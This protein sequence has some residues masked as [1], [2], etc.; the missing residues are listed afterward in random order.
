MKI[1]I[2]H[3]APIQTNCTVGNIFAQAR[4]LKSTYFKA[5][6]VLEQYWQVTLMDSS[7]RI[8]QE[9]KYLHDLC[10]NIKARI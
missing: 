7:S 6:V 9:A 2:V 4:N 8:H 5:V 3:L 1:D 10:E